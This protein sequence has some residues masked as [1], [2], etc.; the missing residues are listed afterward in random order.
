MMNKKGMD[1]DN[2]IWQDDS[3]SAAP[4]VHQITEAL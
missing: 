1:T 3:W 4:S 2:K